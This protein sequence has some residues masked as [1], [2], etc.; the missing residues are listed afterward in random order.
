M[1]DGSYLPHISRKTDNGNLANTFQI[2]PDLNV[3]QKHECMQPHSDIA[4]QLDTSIQLMPA[5]SLPF[6]GPTSAVAACN[7]NTT[8]TDHWYKKGSNCQNI[9][10]CIYLFARCK[11]HHRMASEILVERTTCLLS[12]PF[13]TITIIDYQIVV[14]NV[15]ICVYLFY[16]SITLRMN[17]SYTIY[18]I[19]LNQ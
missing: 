7:D 12:I 16:I 15:R 5:W 1:L 8:H 11:W 6:C 10:N 18:I 17:A 4:L 2:Q 3:F 13:K 19:L 14:W 9:I